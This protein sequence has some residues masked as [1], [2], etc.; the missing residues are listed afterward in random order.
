MSLFRSSNANQAQPA[1]TGFFSFSNPS[2]SQ[3]SGST[4]LFGQPQT[5]Q[6]SS[7]PTF[8]FGAPK[9]Q[10]QQTGG[11]FGT[12]QTQQSGGLFG[13]GTQPQQQ[14]RGLFGASQP[15]QQ[16]GGLFGTST[17][18][19]QQSAFGFGQSQQQPQQPQR[20]LDQTLRFGQSQ[21]GQPGPQSLWEEGRGLN[22]FR[23]IPVQMNIVKNKWDPTILSSPLRTYLYQ[24]VES[25]TDALKYRPG[26]GE[27]E[28]KWEEAVSKRPGPDWVP[29]L[30]Q[31]FFQLGRK[32]QIQ[33]EAVQRCNMMLQEINT[34]LDVQLDKHRQNM[35]TRLEECKRRQAAAAQRTLSLAVKVQ[36]LR[37][38]GYVMDNAEEELKAKL[39]KL[40]RE[41]FDPSLNA[42]E[43]EIW[44]RMLGIR[45]RAKRLKTEMEKIAPAAA[46]DGEGT[47]L[48]EDTIKAAKKTL[49]A[50]EIQLRHLQKE[51]ELVQQEYDEWEKISKDRDND[52][53]R[54]R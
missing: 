43:Q 4:S 52:V 47:T 20:P 35:A 42:R 2:S 7:L 54:R 1:K 38:R 19:Q 33:M 34:S 15:Q 14:S 26:P 6:Q 36:I 13:T 44:A 21:Q 50:Y 27:D 24:H 53:P 41:V 31:G 30:I 28:D 22:V 12:S 8:G 48:D 49:E 32:A 39:E 40:Q 23:S 17:Q 9:S 29:L 45:E 46:A 5:Q 51:L 3:P 10:P 18:P 11:L 16:P 37:N 25:E